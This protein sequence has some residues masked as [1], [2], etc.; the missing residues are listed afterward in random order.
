MSAKF[1][2][3]MTQGEEDASQGG[4]AHP[5][6][7]YSHRCPCL[8]T[9]PSLSSAESHG[10]VVKTTVAASGESVLTLMTEV[11]RIT[12]HQMK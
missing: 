7:A 2:G 3:K 5:L 8:H 6:R 4:L 9:L 11:T 10:A 1:P 12:N